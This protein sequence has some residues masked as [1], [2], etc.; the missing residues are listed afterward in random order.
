M[1][2]R[3]AEGFS[4]PTRAISEAQPVL[5][6]NVKLLSWNNCTPRHPPQSVLSNNTGM[7]KTNAWMDNADST[8]NICSPYLCISDS[9]AAR[10]LRMKPDSPD[11]AS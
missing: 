10:W 6:E 2:R 5:V 1:A 9:T 11:R 7:K 3:S 4:S 8:F